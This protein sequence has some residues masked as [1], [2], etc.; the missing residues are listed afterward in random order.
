MAS[1]NKRTRWEASAT[2]AVDTNWFTTNIAPENKGKQSKF[3]ILMMVPT[4]TVVEV[5][6]ADGTTNKTGTL[7]GGTALTA[8]AWYVF[9]ITVPPGYTFN[10]QHKT[11]TQ[12]VAC[13]I[14][15]TS[16]NS[17]F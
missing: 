13:I 6:I 16:G 8:S 17:E 15:E 1:E 12:N 7:N 3:T 11:G 2:V 5:D 9:N 4:S 10:I 14:D